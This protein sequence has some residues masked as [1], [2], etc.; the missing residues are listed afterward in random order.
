MLTLTDGTLF[1]PCCCAIPWG[2]TSGL[3]GLDAEALEE[4]VYSFKVFSATLSSCEVFVSAGL[5]G[6]I[7]VC[8]TF[9]CIWC[10]SRRCS[11]ASSP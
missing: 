4:C 3:V 5:G 1:P 8:L 7:R 11:L 10:I 9:A 2:R 6:A